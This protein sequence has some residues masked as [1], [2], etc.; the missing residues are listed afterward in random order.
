MLFHGSFDHYRGLVSAA[1]AAVTLF[2][3]GGFLFE[4]LRD[5]LAEEV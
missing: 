4:R 2:A 1:V 5:T 3:V